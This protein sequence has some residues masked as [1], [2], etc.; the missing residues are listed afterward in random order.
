ME[1]QANAVWEPAVAHH[2]VWLPQSGSKVD[3]RAYAAA[4]LGAWADVAAYESGPAIDPRVAPIQEVPPA[5][6]SAHPDLL[7]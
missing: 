1:Y 6:A 7:N 5:A 3:N 4:A 2:T